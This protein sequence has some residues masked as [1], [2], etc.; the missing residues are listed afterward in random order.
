[1]EFPVG[2]FV[3]EVVSSLVA[4]NTVIAKPSAQTNLIAHYA[5]KLMHEAGVPTGAVQLMIG[6]GSIIGNQLTKDPRIAG[7]ILLVQL[8]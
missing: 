1:M 3:G 8:K 4:G 5:V 2:D 6:S 7:V